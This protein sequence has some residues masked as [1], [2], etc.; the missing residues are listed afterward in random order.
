LVP[1]M[2]ARQVLEE[3]RH[4]LLVRLV[5]RLQPLPPQRLGRLATQLE[6]FFI[7]RAIA[8]E[9]E[10]ERRRAQFGGSAVVRSY[11]RA[12]TTA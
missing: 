10:R 9:R 6:L 11:R 5:P 3:V 4:A 8:G 2:L 7:R 12:T 1:L